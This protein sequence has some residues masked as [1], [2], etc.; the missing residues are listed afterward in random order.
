[1][2]RAQRD[3]GPLPSMIDLTCSCRWST[4]AHAPN[5]SPPGRVPVTAPLRCPRSRWQALLNRLDH[6]SYA[7]WPRLCWQAATR[8]PL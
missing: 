8:Q 3:A 5:A 2:Q 7:D 1:M 6:A 4:L